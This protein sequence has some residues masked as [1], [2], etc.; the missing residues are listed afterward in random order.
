MSS[1][2]TGGSK[3]QPGGLLLIVVAILIP[4]ILLVSVV[5]DAEEKGYKPKELESYSGSGKAEEPTKAPAVTPKGTGTPIAPAEAPPAVIVRRELK[6]T[7]PKGPE[8]MEPIPVEA[9]SESEILPISTNA[10]LFRIHLDRRSDEHHFFIVSYDAKLKN[11]K[12]VPNLDT[13]AEHDATN[14]CVGTFPFVQF[15]NRGNGGAMAGWR[16][17]MD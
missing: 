12:W 3:I 6:P 2:S 15:V 7:G 11:G 5:H 17:R 10:T 14:E 8:E 4:S 13:R 9:G 16:K 1:A